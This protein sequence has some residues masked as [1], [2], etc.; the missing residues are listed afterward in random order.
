T[1]R[2]AAELARGLEL[3]RDGVALPL[4]PIASTLELAPGA[5]GLRTLR[6][7]ITYRAE[8]PRPDGEIVFRDHNFS[9]RPGWREGIATPARG[10]GGPRGGRQPGAARLSGDHAASAATGLGGPLHARVRHGLDLLRGA[11]VGRAERRRAL[12]RPLHGADRGSGSPR[13]L[14]HPHLA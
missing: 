10:L 14:D 7:D 2:Q 3:T 13:P 11:P 5:G 1:A 12:R 8:L 9:A 6:L 4:A